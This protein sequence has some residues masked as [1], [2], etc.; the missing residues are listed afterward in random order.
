MVTTKDFS[1]NP[2]DPFEEVVLHEIWV[3]VRS[4]S[5][6]SGQITVTPRAN[7][8]DMTS[9]A[10]ILPATGNFGSAYTSYH[11]QLLAVQDYVKGS[12]IGVKI[13]H[14]KSGKHISIESIKLIG[15]VTPLQLTYES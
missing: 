9:R 3:K 2:A 15:V 5:S 12:K 4:V 1:V 11:I 6:S 8:V 14:S 7:Q 13:S 10:V